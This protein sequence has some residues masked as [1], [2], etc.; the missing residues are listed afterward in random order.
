MVA[1]PLAIRFDVAAVIQHH[2]APTTRLEFPQQPADVAGADVALKTG[3]QDHDWTAGGTVSCP[4]QL[5]QSPSEAQA[6]PTA[7][8]V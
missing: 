1:V 2:A 8:R 5:T 4:I 6:A 7:L 3:Q